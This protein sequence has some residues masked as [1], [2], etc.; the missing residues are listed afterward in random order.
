ML[1][2]FEEVNSVLVVCT[3]AE[4]KYTLCLS[5]LFFSGCKTAGGGGSF[6]ILYFYFYLI[7]SPDRTQGKLFQRFGQAKYGELS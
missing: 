2:V 7:F 5:P 4:L 3:N 6:I 1:V